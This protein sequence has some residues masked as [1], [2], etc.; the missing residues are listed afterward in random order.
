MALYC[1]CL[2]AFAFL[3]RLLVKLATT[4]LGQ[5]TRFLAGTLEPT[6]GGVKILIFFNADTRHTNT[7]FSS[8][9]KKP[10]TKAGT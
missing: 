4:Q 10:G 7:F 9:T 6:Q 8:D 5:D 3:G 2:F 1:R